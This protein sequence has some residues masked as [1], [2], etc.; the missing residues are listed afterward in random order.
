[1]TQSALSI[2]LWGM[3][4]GISMISF[5]T[6]PALLIRSCSVVVSSAR[7][8]AGL[9]KAGR[10]INAAISRAERTLLFMRC[11]L[12]W[13]GHYSMDF[14]HEPQPFRRGFR[15]GAKDIL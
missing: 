4:S 9:N 1:M 5:R 13:V 2:R 15:A 6:V 8:G 11:T 3:L 7:E 14:E 10:P 12:L